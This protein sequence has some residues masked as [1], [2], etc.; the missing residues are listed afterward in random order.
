MHGGS[1]NIRYTAGD[2]WRVVR[3]GAFKHHGYDQ[4]VALAQHLIEQECYAGRT[5][6]WGDA[7]IF[8][9]AGWH[10]QM[11]AHARSVRGA[12]VWRLGRTKRGRWPRSPR[13]GLRLPHQ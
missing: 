2:H 12:R 1:P 9:A 6:S 5:F 8:G 10:Q 7:Y 11:V 13:Q 4:Y 3:G